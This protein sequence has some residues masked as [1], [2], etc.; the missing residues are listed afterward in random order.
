MKHGFFRF[1]KSVLFLLALTACIVTAAR[2]LEN[3][4][5]KIKYNAFFDEARENKLDVLFLGSSHVIDGINPVQLYGYTGSTELL[6]I[7]W[8]AMAASCLQHTG[9]W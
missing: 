5:S 8:A 6:P 1:V 9:N 3:K 2:L 4:D 7:I